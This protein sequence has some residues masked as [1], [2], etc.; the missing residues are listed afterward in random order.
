MVRG[1]KVGEFTVKSCGF[2]AFRGVTGWR[3]K[4]QTRSM[5]QGMAPVQKGC[6]VRNRPSVRM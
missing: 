6:F 4:K 5:E 3:H 1:G 2:N